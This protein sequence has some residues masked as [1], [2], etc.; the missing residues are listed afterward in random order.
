MKLSLELGG[1]PESLAALERLLNEVVCAAEG[2]RGVLVTCEGGEPRTATFNLDHEHTQTVVPLMEQAVRQLAE[3]GDAS[4]LIVTVENSL[5]P[6]TLAVP[7]R[8]G[9]RS[10]GMFCLFN[11]P[12]A[13]N[14]LLKDSP[15][16]YHLIVDKLEVTIQS[17]R[18][19]Q[20]L[21]NERRWLEAVVQHSSDGVVI[22][23]KAGTV[24]GYNLTMTRLTGWAPGEAAGRPSHEV[25]PLR[26]STQPDASSQSLVRLGRRFF[27]ERT[28]PVE[29]T[30]ETRRGDVLEVE[31]T[32]VPLFDEK[33]EP[34]GWVMTLRDVTRRKEMERLQ[35]V[36]LS[37]VSHELHTPIAVIK[38]FAGLLS[39]PEMNLSPEVA[40][41]KA[42]IIREE[43]QRL[44]KMVGQMLDAT[45]IQ[46][47][48]IKLEREP[49]HLG[50][51][52]RQAVKKMQPVV[53][54]P[55]ELELDGD[56]PLV[57]VD[58]GKLEQV[59]T[60]L[61][62]NAGK[63]GSGGIRVRARW[64]EVR[65]TVSVTDR[66]PGVPRDERDRIFSPFERGGDPL[67][68]KVRGAGL[69]LFISKSIVEA[70]GGTIG[71]EEG[72]EG[73]ASFNFTIPREVL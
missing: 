3:R 67:K 52:L 54:V 32:G 34:L 73:G 9:D 48:G 4:D 61:I 49:T 18:L 43:A 57:Q 2:Q 71:V 37:A 63:Y 15:G 55:V 19:L 12:D 45:R 27:H 42:A 39:D 28:D 66:G 13:P 69:G 16:I 21:L 50:S 68:A 8:S 47:G 51:L 17:A 35:K 36:F 40:R 53:K 41:E 72:P 59:L 64:D 23:D 62:E 6:E 46:A 58:S 38:G 14:S 60:N 5:G 26:L 70:H 10:V 33:E 29:A 30:L 20:R 44:E 22:L 31:V 65:F 56:P 25:F 7:V 24:V 1:E 11:S